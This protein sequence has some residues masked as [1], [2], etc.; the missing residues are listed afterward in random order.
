MTRVF[1]PDK[2]AQM[3]PSEKFW[4]SAL[5]CVLISAMVTAVL[6]KFLDREGKA[7]R[8]VRSALFGGIG[9]MF[10][11]VCLKFCERFC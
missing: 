4:R 2:L 9:G 10:A 6:L 5:F 1:Y 3:L 11:A 8:D 7:D